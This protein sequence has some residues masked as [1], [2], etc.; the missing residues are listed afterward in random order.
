MKKK[1]SFVLPA[2]NEEV[3]IRFIYNDIVSIFKKSWL[4]NKY[5][6]EIIFVDDWSTDNTANEIKKLSK[7]DP[8]V[9]AVIFSRNFW[10][11]IALTAWLEYASW[12]AVITLDVD[13]QHPVEKIPD[14]IKYWE[15]WYKLV[16]NIR[17]VNKWAWFFKNLSSNLFYKLF[18]SI[19]DFKLEPWATD[20]R[21]L[22]KR[23]VKEYLAFR[24]KNRIYR[25]L[26]DWLD[27]K[28]KAL[29][30][31]SYERADRTAPRYTFFKLLKLSLNSITSFSLFPLKLVWFFWLFITIISFTFLVI[32]LLSYLNIIKV[33]FTNVAVLIWFNTFLIGIVLV[34]MWLMSFYIANIHEE[35][36]RRPLYIVEEKINL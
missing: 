31:D 8:N 32:V 30:F 1:I 16:Y 6:Y 9:K 3:N 10:K 5:D 23:L 11:E 33:Y 26:I 2:Y 17:P 34:S 28:K 14:F 22:D 7:K 20:Y 36:K 18:N 15:K 29:V 12:D 4:S 24:E 35:T 25:W 21:L 13:W 27:F 19:S